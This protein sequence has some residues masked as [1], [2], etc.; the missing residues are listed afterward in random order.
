MPVSCPCPEPDQSSQCP[1]SQFLKIHLNIILFS[2]PWSSKWSVSHTFPHQNAVFIFF[3]SI[4]ATCP[5]HLILLN[6]I[7]QIMFGEEYISLSS[8]LCSL[9]HTHFTSSYLGTN[10]LLSTLFSDILSPCSSLSVSDQVSL[11]YK[12]KGKIIVL[13]IFIFIFLDSKLQDKRF[14]TK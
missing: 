13:C 14:C 3:S 7:T 12:T 2:T 5:G 4:C 9:L 8:S 10:I 1:S 6:L 11:P